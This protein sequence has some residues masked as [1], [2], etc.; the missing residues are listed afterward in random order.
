MGMLLSECHIDKSLPVLLL[1]PAARLGCPHPLCQRHIAG[2]T[3][4]V[5]EQH[6]DLSNPS[7]PSQKQGARGRQ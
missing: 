1:V 4:R 3:S 6:R 2:G 7:H 5:T